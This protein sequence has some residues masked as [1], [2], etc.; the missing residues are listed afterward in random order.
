VLRAPL[1]QGSAIRSRGIRLAG[2]VLH[3]LP[4]LAMLAG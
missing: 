3:E 4:T 2:C 1:R